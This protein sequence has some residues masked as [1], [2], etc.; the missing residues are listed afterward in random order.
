MVCRC[1]H[2]HFTTL[3][4]CNRLARQDRWEESTAVLSRLRNLPTTHDYVQTEIKEMF[5][6]L[7]YERRLVGGSSAKDL[8]KEMWTIPG[9]RKRALITI[10]LMICQQMTGMYPD[11]ARH[12]PSIANS[13]F[14]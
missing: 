2:N 1:T 10:G 12:A 8:L 9:N 3:L 11:R 13:S 14:I 6:Q 7:E 4:T 5:D